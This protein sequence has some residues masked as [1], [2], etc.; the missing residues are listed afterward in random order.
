MS[1]PAIDLGLMAEHLTAHEGIINKLELYQTKVTIVSLKK[2]IVSQT[3]MMRDHVRVMLALIN[4]NQKNEYVELSPINKYLGFYHMQTAEGQNNSP[5]DKWIAL[6]G[7][8]T[9]KNMSN[10]NYGSALMMQD[11]YVRNIHVQMALQQFEMLYIYGEIIARM[12]WMFTPHASTHEQF[13]TFQHYEY[14]LDQ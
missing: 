14:I 5:R 4:P 1:L 10:N 3:N 2:I 11:P 6:D 7:H 12:G 9:A 13:N 8:T